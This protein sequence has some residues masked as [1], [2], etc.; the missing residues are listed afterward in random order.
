MPVIV[1][2]APVCFISLSHSRSGRL[3]LT[4]SSTCT[5]ASALAQLLDQ[6]DALLQLRLLRLELLHLREHRSQLLRLG[7]GLR[8]VLVELRRL[9]ERPEPPADAA[10]PWRS[11]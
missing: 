1:K 11:G 5:G 9:L 2:S 3:L 8:D 7:F 10:A 6:R 4:S